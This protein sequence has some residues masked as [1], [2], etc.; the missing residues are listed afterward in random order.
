VERRTLSV[1]YQAFPA[2]RDFPQLRVATD[3][4]RML[5]V[6]RAHLKPIA[7]TD[8]RIENCL[9]VRLRSRQSTARCVLQYTLQ[10]VEPRTNRRWEHW[11]TGF[12]YAADHEAERLWRELAA[13]AP[14]REIPNR[15]LSFEPV[16][17][18]P[19]LQMLV[20]VFPYDRKLPHLCR[21]MNGG[22]RDLEPWLLAR[23]GPGDW[24]IEEHAVE[25][26]RYRTELGAALRCHLKVR[27]VASGRSETLRCYLKVYRDDRGERTFQLL[28]S[29]SARA[30]QAGRPYAVVNPVGYSS[31]LHTLLLEEAPGSALQ[32]ILL[33]GPDPIG[34]VRAVARA[35]AAF[36][37]DAIEVT[38]HSP[39][40][41]QLA[42][43]EQACSL[44]QWGCPELRGDV[45]AITAAVAQSLTDVPPA[46]I[47]GD[48]K[49]EHV[50]LC[51]DCVTFIDLDAATLGDPVRDPA[52]LYAHIAGR[53]GLDTMPPEAAR[54]AG[55][56]FVDEYFQHVPT[57]W[58]ER[59]ALHAAA[60]LL[61]V[62]RG[63]FKRQERDWRNKLAAAV[64]AAKRS[65]HASS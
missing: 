61:E 8:T 15:W 60:A 45:A 39:R 54:T 42:D 28:Q 31:A 51:G 59:F 53:L 4:G 36:N 32:Q 10:L 57:A 1:A 27:E 6:F 17:Y 9:A 2:D 63:I 52:H 64:A 37:Q 3:L 24:R 58:R 44:I 50:L 7:G 65:L 11:V 47:H 56:A 18:I 20:Q 55:A 38:R 34:A 30:C 25:P 21:I 35:V 43:V 23:L 5:D 13:G 22:I 16:A 14:R 49:T 41:D 33:G 26:M 46:P 40:T 29:L 19:A 62:A 48:L 12:L